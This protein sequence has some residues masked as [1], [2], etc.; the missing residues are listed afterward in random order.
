VGGDRGEKCKF[1]KIGVEKGYHR[2]GKQREKTRLTGGKKGE[3]GKKATE[4]T[5]ANKTG[6]KGRKVR[7]GI[8]MEGQ[9]LRLCKWNI[10]SSNKG[11]RLRQ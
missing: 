10:K 5:G 6:K 11:R 3:S 4:T 1:L 2:L 7:R 9:I 8:L